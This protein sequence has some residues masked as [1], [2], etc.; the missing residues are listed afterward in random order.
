M[1]TEDHHIKVMDFGLAT[2]QWMASTNRCLA[3]S[4]SADAGMLRG[5]PA[6]MAPEQIRGR[7]QTA[8]PTSS[9]SA[10]FY[11]LLSGVN[12]FQRG[13]IEATLTAIA[14]DL[15]AH[16]HDRLSA[17][18]PSI[19]DIVTRLL[20]KDPV[21][22]HQSFREVRTDLRRVAADL[23]GLRALAVVPIVERP[24]EDTAR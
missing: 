16:L 22:R 5:T 4:T 20:G 10:F 11:E 8:G 19:G 12:P 23:S 18:P 9:R 24:D 6:Y 15:V 21:V 14:S 13:T 7:R 2:C 17:I 1:L 3:G